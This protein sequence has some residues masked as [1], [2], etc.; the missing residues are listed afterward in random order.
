MHYSINGLNTI[1]M[2]KDDV[3]SSSVQFSSSIW[4]HLP[5]FSSTYQ[6]DDTIA[7]LTWLFYWQNVPKKNNYL[8][9]NDSPT[10]QQLYESQESLSVDGKTQRRGYNCCWWSSFCA[11]I[12]C[13]MVRLRI[14]SINVS[15][16][17]KQSAF[18]KLHLKWT[19]IIKIS[20]ATF[21]SDGI[22]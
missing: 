7:R 8:W 14:K 4:Q 6:Y 18:I 20:G 12:N 5:H 22:R 19:S 13:S 10:W 2:I 1:I 21:D 9:K 16:T 3:M 11:T 15:R 17:T